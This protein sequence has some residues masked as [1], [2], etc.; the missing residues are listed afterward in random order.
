[1]F[2]EMATLAAAVAVKGVKR[3]GR[4]KGCREW[5][6][7]RVRTAVESFVVVVVVVD[8]RGVVRKNMAKDQFRFQE[9][10]GVE[11]RLEWNSDPRVTGADA[12]PWAVPLAAVGGIQ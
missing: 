2:L 6:R 10:T 5:G 1:M 4:R 8:S 11:K 7:V 12:I 3:V 9:R